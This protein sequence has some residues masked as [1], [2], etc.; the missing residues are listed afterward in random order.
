MRD[1]IKIEQALFGYH[2]GHNLV[3]A[4]VPLAPRVRQFLA[5]ITDSSGPENA[6][7]F[8]VAFTGLPVPETDFYALFCTWPAPEMPR[9]GCVWSHV[10]LIELA[11]LA[12]IPDF[13]QLRSLC[14]RPVSPLRIADYQRPL[15]FDCA[16]TNMAGAEPLD[17][18]RTVQL[19]RALYEHPAQ[20]IVVLDQA[21]APWELAIFSVWSQQWPRLRREFAFSVGSLGDR[22]QAGVPFDLQIAPLSSER[23]WR[24]IDLPTLVLN[25]TSPAP[26][27]FAAS[28][29]T[30]IDSAVEDLKDGAQSVLRQFFFDF[31]SDTEKPRAAFS[32][33]AV[34][35]G[36]M[37]Y[38][39]NA[40]WGA[41]LRFVGEE[42]PSQTE[43]VRLKRTLTALPESLTSVEKLERAWTIASFILGARE[44]EAY[45]RVDIDFGNAALHFWTQKRDEVVTLL[46]RLVRRKESPLAAS[47][48][49]AIANAVDCAALKYISE[50]HDELVPM[51]I[52][53]HPALAFEVDTWHLQGHVQSQI[54]EALGRLTLKEE[55]W[56]KIVGAM[57]IAATY[58]SIRE[59]V[60]R[61]GS[62][63]MQGAFR[64]LEHPVAQQMLPSQPWREALA[65]PAAELLNRDNKLSP[66]ELAF[67]AWCIPS[68]IVHRI[69]FAERDDV[70]NLANQPLENLPPPLR[71][72]TAFLLTALGLGATTDAGTSL[73]VRTFYPLHDALAAREYSEESWSLLS[74]QLH[75]LG[76]WRDWDRCEKLRRA[77][78]AWLTQH[79]KAGNLLREVA[80]TPERRKLARRVSD[81]QIE[82]DDFI[83]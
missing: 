70:Q 35:H 64:W 49:G 53:H 13:A 22:R 19:V 71:V 36:I 54:Y 21:G 23:L 9:P 14:I 74:P 18:K 46:G 51:I 20:G 61:S 11:D 47:F 24:R 80:T 39:S 25:Y 4:S 42:F 77:V 10:L 59:A 78:N 12:R 58:V 33:L 34:A 56:G 27:L 44:A 48:V 52:S 1:S 62:F 28:P 69:L 63:V 43:A 82:A 50:R 31:G 57:L 6:T 76:L 66:A 3:A 17:I 83:D 38:G 41:L 2:A 60:G 65:S 40:D 8:E 26:D 30:W 79:V 7:G 5:T 72:P 55:D 81:S 75:Y 67:S 73:I 37:A 68:E 15:T 16:R 45:P 32:K 29:A